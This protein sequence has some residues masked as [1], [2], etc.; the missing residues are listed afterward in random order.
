MNENFSVISAR[1]DLSEQGLIVK[2]TLM[3]N[4]HKKIDQVII[5]II[6][7]LFIVLAVYLKTH[8]FST[9]C[10]EKHGRISMKLH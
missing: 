4:G 9:F 10:E 1:L 2:T 6:T 8:T 5:I 7:H 3:K